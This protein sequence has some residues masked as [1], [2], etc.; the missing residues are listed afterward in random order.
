MKKHWLNFLPNAFSQVRKSAVE[1]ELLALRIEE[2]KEKLR[3]AQKEYELNEDMI[4]WWLRT[5]YDYS[6]EQI[7]EAKLKSK[8]Q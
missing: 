1:Q 8:E 4:F 6:T 7:T 2:L 5:E 3:L